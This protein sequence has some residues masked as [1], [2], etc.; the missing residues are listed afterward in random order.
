MC[1][2]L[3]VPTFLQS[4]KPAKTRSFSVPTRYT[5]NVKAPFPYYGN[6]RRH[7]PDI[8]ARLGPT[9]VYV[10]PFA[11]SLGVL[12]NR[13][14]IPTGGLEVVNDKNGH[15]ANL[16]RSIKLHPKETAHW[17]DHPATDQDNRARANHVKDLEHALDQKLR[18]H[19]DACDPQL[20]AYWAYVVSST[21]GNRLG[22]SRPQAGYIGVQN[23]QEP[24]LPVWLTQLAD[25]LR[26]V[27]ILAGDWRSTL[28]PGATHA[29]RLNPPYA[30]FLDPPYRT[31]E[32]TDSLYKSD[33]IDSDQTAEDSYEWAVEKG[34]DKR[35]RIAYCMHEGD[36][37]VPDGWTSLTYT[38]A[39]IKREDRQHRRDE[40]IFS[41]HCVNTQHTLY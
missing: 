30:A 12:I 25:R 7:A 29:N 39:G 6:K 23:R 31:H 18:E 32:R 10:E 21:V 16:W 27:K 34:E 3:H 15:V 20:A 4:Y 1:G 13:P 38:L 5:K 40:I 28:T 41:P 8:W 9:K 33:A 2:F 37:P 36:F 22:Y 35:W 17:A 11:G 14:H 19:P 24:P 26:Y